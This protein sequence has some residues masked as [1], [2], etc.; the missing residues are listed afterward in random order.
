[1]R[2]PL[3]FA[4][5]LALALPAPAPAHETAAGFVGEV[6]SHGPDAAGV[7]D[8]GAEAPAPA[9]GADGKPLALD[10]R[11]K[12]VAGP[13]H[14]RLPAAWC[15]TPRTT[16]DRAHEVDNGA[17]RYHA[18]YAL[19]AD[20]PD[21]FGRLASTLQADAFQASALLELAYGRAVRFDIGTGCGPQYLDIT[22]V[23]LPQ[24]SAQ[25]RAVADTATGT[26]DAVT[27]GIRAAGFE[28]IRST[29]TV[30]SAAGR[31]RN[32]LV[33]IDGPSP[34]A[35]CGQ[36]TSFD[37]P[38]RDAS[39][40]NNLGG[41]VALVF[42][43]GRGGFCSSNTVRHEIGHNLG[44]LQPVAPHAFDGA[45]CSDAYED[46]MCYSQAPRVG[47][48]QRGRYFDYGNDDYWDPPRGRALPWWTANL[49]RFLCPDQHCNVAPSRGRD[50]T[51]GGDADGDGIPDARD[52]CPHVAGDAC[53]APART[54]VRETVRLTA[55]RVRRGWKVTVT[56]R[57]EG[58]AIVTVR[59]RPRPRRAVRTVLTKRTKLPRTIRRTVRCATRPRAGL[60]PAGPAA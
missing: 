42:P 60:L 56:A 57:G 24:T 14:R 48:G 27:D 6:D 29:D 21:R 4:C 32:F 20:A 28:T 37:D 55:K 33:W 40:L 1:M 7:V 43:D 34:P 36:A 38:T 26:L 8:R 19:P 12:P 51:P 9:G 3:A 49:N 18:I 10:A 52:A 53:T 13:A 50:A 31:N 25:L 17:Y 2:I 47:N 41:K 58:E 59:C 5:L 54:P 16:D 44:A 45:H 46:T 22:V 30:E 23:R 35:A 15:G 11:G 39:N